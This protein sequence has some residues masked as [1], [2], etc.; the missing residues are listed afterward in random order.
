MQRIKIELQGSGLVPDIGIEDL[1]EY[2]I[3]SK[4][5]PEEIKKIISKCYN[6]NGNDYIIFEERKRPFIKSYVLDYKCFTHHPYLNDD[7]WGPR[8]DSYPK[9]MIPGVWN[10]DILK[11]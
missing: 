9:G 4:K 7:D 2:L 3:A 8:P 11:K 1:E 10:D 6:K 5:S